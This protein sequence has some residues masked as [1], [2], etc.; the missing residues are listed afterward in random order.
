M[1]CVSLFAVSVS[2]SP[3]FGKSEVPG[4]KGRGETGEGVA[5]RH[6]FRVQVPRST[7]SSSMSNPGWPRT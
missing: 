4:P 7:H 2:V 5:T 6:K 3:A 1:T